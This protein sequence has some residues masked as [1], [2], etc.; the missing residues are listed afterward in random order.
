MKLPFDPDEATAALAAA[1]KRLAKVIERA[2]PFTV[3]PLHMQ[4][5]FQA[6]L[7]SIVY[8]QLSGK[9]AKVIHERVVA[10][11]EQHGRLT[12]E[13]LVATPTA[14]LRAAGL[15]RAKALA[16]Q[17]LAAK[18]LDGTVPSLARMRKMSDA[19]IVEHLVQ[20][21]GIGRWTV[22]MLLIFRLGRPDVLPSGDLG[23]R[24]GFMLTYKTPALPSPRDL[25]ARGERWRPFRSVASWYL[26]RA[27]DLVKA[28]AE[29]AA[30]WP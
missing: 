18:T 21:R 7:R 15:S 25:E 12:A 2:G 22:E 26:W 6:L 20:V 19:E 28:S 17:D 1:D 16:V 24:K 30:L 13:A 9:V 27:V 4:S 11:I 14:A 5:P 10:A 29:G 8:Q 3:R 23:V